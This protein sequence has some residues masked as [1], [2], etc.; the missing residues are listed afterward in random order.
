MFPRRRQISENI[1]GELIKLL[2]RK[3][4]AQF[5]SELQG[6]CD[7]LHGKEAQRTA[8]LNEIQTALQNDQGDTR[9]GVD[10]AIEDYLLEGLRGVFLDPYLRQHHFLR[11][12]GFAADLAAHVFERP[13]GYQPAEQRRVFTVSD[14]PLDVGGM[15]KAAASTQEFSLF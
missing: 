7:T 15:V 8:I 3:E 5:A 1:I 12:G 11:D 10:L 6:V 9:S 2:P 4:Q 14:L 13:S